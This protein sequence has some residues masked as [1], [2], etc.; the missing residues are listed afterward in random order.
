M[1]GQD[2]MC[3]ITVG[4]DLSY[5]VELD[6]AKVPNFADPRD[7]RFDVRS[8]T[9]HW[10]SQSRRAAGLGTAGPTVPQ[11]YDAPVQG[12]AWTQG[13]LRRPDILR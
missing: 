2:N 10:N 9:R 7:Q 11:A 12:R 6:V 3:E 4:C 5:P 13:D 1:A 8:S